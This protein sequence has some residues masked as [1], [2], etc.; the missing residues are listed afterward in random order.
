[1]EALPQREGV[2]PD[3]SQYTLCHVHPCPRVG[4]SG[5]EDLLP[6]RVTRHRFIGQQGSGCGNAPEPEL[7]T[8]TADLWNDPRVS[9]RVHDPWAG[10]TWFFEKGCIQRKPAY[11]VELMP[12][13]SDGEETGELADDAASV[14]MKIL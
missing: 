14:Q 3:S 7:C 8:S 11:A 9:H 10:E 12:V 4:R 2:V 5:S 1:M 13:G 6:D